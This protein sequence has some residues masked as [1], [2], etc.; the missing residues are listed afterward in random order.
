MKKMLLFL[1]VAVGLLA[2]SLGWAVT[3]TPTKTPTPTWTPTLSPTPTV[4][5]TPSPVAIKPTT[6][7]RTYVHP[8]IFK[9][10]DG[11]TALGTSAL[12]GSSLLWYAQVASQ[13]AAV[14]S[15][16]TAEVRFNVILPA[17]YK[18][19]KGVNFYAYA[20]SSVTYTTVSLTTSLN[21]QGFNA[22]TSTAQ[23]FAG[24][25]TNVITQ[26]RS[27]LIPGRMSRVLLTTAPTN[28]GFSYKPGD[29]INVDIVRKDAGVGLLYLYGIEVEYDYYFGEPR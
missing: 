24:A 7:A 5:Y 12:P 21:T 16:G 11:I 19:T 1:A 9:Q 17:N 6:L 8:S 15:T 29:L 22:L 25:E 3:D 4:T 13:T 23:Y 14:M 27:P 2:P 18:A 10:A 28:G 20:S 26:G